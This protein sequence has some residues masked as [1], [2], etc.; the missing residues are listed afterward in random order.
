MLYV[1]AIILC[2]TIVGCSHIRTYER[3][4]NSST[5]AQNISVKFSRDYDNIGIDE[6]REEGI[7]IAKFSKCTGDTSCYHVYVDL[8]IKDHKIQFYFKDK[9]VDQV[10]IN[11]SNIKEVR[12]Y[13]NR[14]LSCKESTLCNSFHWAALLIT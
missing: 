14:A 9:F 3:T 12:Y 13:E 1:T 11:P 5:E 10:V 8:S 7:S 2:I 4:D 6:I